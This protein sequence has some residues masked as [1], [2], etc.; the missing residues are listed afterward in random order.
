MAVRIVDLLEM[1]D[2]QQH[3]RQRLVLALRI[4]HQTGEQVVELVAVAQLGQRIGTAEQVEARLLLQQLHLQGQGG[5]VFTVI[6][7]KHQYQIGQ[8]EAQ[9]QQQGVAVF[10]IQCHEDQPWQV[11][12]RQC[13]QGTAAAHGEVEG[14]RGAE[15]HRGQGRDQLR[16]VVFV[17]VQRPGMGLAPAQGGQQNQPPVMVE[18]ALQLLWR[19]EPFG[20][21]Q[22]AGRQQA[23]EGDDAK[24]AAADDL[25][26]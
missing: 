1:I 9:G 22:Q 19:G 7:A 23:G 2:V 6:T 4:G 16:V 20:A 17:T 25:G 11:Q 21:V 10:P 8:I 12:Q 13:E 18:P 5:V 3:Q 26:R 14:H 24:Q 15:G